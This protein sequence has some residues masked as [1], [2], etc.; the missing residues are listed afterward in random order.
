[1]SLQKQIEVR[2]C[3]LRVPAS[4]DVEDA[5]FVRNDCHSPAVFR[6]QS[7]QFLRRDILCPRS[8]DGGTAGSSTS[9]R[10]ISAIIALASDLLTACFLN[11]SIASSSV[12]RCDWS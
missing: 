2:R 10:V 1:M 11:F 5:T 8:R 3:G 9:R 4:E 12:F 7:P 6:H